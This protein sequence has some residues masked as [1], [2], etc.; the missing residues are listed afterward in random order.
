MND[1]GM[2]VTV[3]YGILKRTTREFQFARA[4]HDLPLIV[5]ADHEGVNLVHGPG[6][7]L[8]LFPVFALDEQSIILP[9]NSLLL[10]YTDGVTEARN[11]N[12]EFFGA[13]RLH[14]TLRT[15]LP[16][17]AQAAC[18]AILGAIQSFS[19]EATPRD[20]ITLVAVQLAR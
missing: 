5:D 3:L 15:A 17:S 2:F 20:D 4:G 9:E 12:S 14:I 10:M 18:D 16:A 8:G 1:W 11:A 19:G 6:Q 7:P 13:E